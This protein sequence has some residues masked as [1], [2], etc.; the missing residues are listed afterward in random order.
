MLTIER[1]DVCICLGGGHETDGAII[2][3]VHWVL[4]ASSIG[5]NELH[6]IF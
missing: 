2:A 1:Q 6:M 4:A 5:P 3:I